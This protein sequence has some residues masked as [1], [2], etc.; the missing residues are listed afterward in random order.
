MPWRSEGR[1][2][3][4]RRV[5]QP[6]A[7]RQAL[8]DGEQ[9]AEIVALHRQEALQHGAAI[10]GLVGE[11]HLLHHVQPALLE[12]HVLGAAEPD[13]LGAEQP[14]GLGVGG[15]VGIG[16]DADVAEF[17]PPSRG[18]RGKRRRAPAVS[19]GAAP[20]ST[21]P[22]LPSRV[23]MSPSRRVRPS[24]VTQRM[25]A[26]V[27]LHPDDADDA[28][29]ADAAGDHR[30]M[31][32]HSAA[33]GD[34]AGGGMHAAHVVGRGLAA[35][36]DRGL[37]LR[38]GGLRGL[39]GEDDA[40]PPRRRGWRRCRSGSRRACRADRPGGAEARSARGGRRA[41]PLLR[42]EMIPSWAS[43]TATFS[44]ARDER[45]TRTASSTASRPASRV[46]SICISSR[47]RARQMPP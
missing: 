31:A 47:S 14:R 2:S 1:N 22:R 41:S 4:K 29:Q 45:G 20:A 35:D 21:S 7:D 12:E 10:L 42:G 5:E 27:Q 38:G 40:C 13:P 17:A 39:A 6:D 3:C 30:G 23:M 26:R 44:V 34:H 36:Q 9:L 11:D 19:I 43:A 15:G 46:N 8:H 32:G 28:G 33:L 24:G 25:V 16:A 37:A 18:A